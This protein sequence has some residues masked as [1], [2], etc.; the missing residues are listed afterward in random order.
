MRADTIPPAMRN[1]L[2]RQ[3]IADLFDE[4]HEPVRAL[5]RG[6]HVYAAAAARG[7]G[8]VRLGLARRP[9]HRAARAVAAT[10]A[11]Y[12]ADAVRGFLEAIG[13][14]SADRAYG[15]RLAALIAA[16]AAFAAVGDAGPLSTAARRLAALTREPLRAG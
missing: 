13:E 6:A 11:R 16:A 3:L 12:P 7:V 15:E 1:L 10:L 9:L 4:T 8:R 2:N 5:Q 14:L